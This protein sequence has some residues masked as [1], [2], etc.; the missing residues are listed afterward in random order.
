[1]SGSMSASQASQDYPPAG[2]GLR[3]M[4]FLVGYERLGQDYPPAGLGLRPPPNEPPKPLAY[5]SGLPPGRTGIETMDRS[6]SSMDKTLVRTTP[7][8]DWD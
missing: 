4:A 5:A 2:L 1:M 3:L 7:R 8:P 6:R